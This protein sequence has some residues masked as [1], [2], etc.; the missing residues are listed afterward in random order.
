MF[1]Q[2]LRTQLLSNNEIEH[3]NAPSIININEGTV[4]YLNWLRLYMDI[5]QRVALSPDVDR[6][7]LNAIIKHA[8]CNSEPNPSWLGENTTIWGHMHTFMYDSS[9][10]GCQSQC[11][12][13]VG[14]SCVTDLL[15]WVHDIMQ[16]SRTSM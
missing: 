7:F 9:S 11:P 8:L 13:P 14:S 10:H 2:P 5:L 16:I 15:S 3:L 12:I 1:F 6:I 4:N